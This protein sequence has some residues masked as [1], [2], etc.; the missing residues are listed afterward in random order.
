MPHYMGIHTLPG[1]SRDML[2]QATP[3]LEQLNGQAG[4]TR[5]LRSMSSFTESRVV[6]EFEAPSKE[7]LAAV[8]GRLGF[9]H[10]AIIE[11]NTLCDAEGGSV[12][13]TEV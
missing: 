8:F 3:A 9:P 5:F 1:F 12:I 10:D 6:C 4:D 7:A 2:S 13:T 11:M